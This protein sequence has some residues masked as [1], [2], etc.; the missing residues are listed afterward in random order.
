MSKELKEFE[1]QFNEGYFK[2][3]NYLID[4]A[5][6]IEQQKNQYRKALLDV[7]EEINETL[8]WAEMYEA[9]RI[10]DRALKDDPDA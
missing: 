2:N 7:R 5:K 1:N 9:V 8:F 3:A 4:Y 10:I 6:S